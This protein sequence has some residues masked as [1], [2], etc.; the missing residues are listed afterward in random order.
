[1]EDSMVTRDSQRNVVGE[2]TTVYTSDGKVITTNT[3]YYD[4]RPVS[5]SVS[6]RDSKGN[7]ETKNIIGGKI[8][9]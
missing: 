5:Q 8:F 2:I 7:V 9:P 1:M 6:M 3:A 4:G